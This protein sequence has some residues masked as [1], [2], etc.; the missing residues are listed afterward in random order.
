[1]IYAN[2]EISKFPTTTT[3]T[4][5]KKAIIISNSNNSPSSS[6][7]SNS[8][9]TSFSS[10][11]GK[12]LKEDSFECISRSHDLYRLTLTSTH[13]L[14]QLVQS[15]Y[16]VD[17]LSL[18]DL[19]GCHTFRHKDCS[20]NVGAYICFFFYIKR[21]KGLFSSSIKFPTSSSNFSL[22]NNNNYHNNKTNKVADSSS[23]STSSTSSSLSSSSQSHNSS[24][25]KYFREKTPLVFHIKKL[26]LKFHENLHIATEWKDSTL[27]ILQARFSNWQLNK[28]MR[29]SLTSNGNT[30]NENN[31]KTI[32]KG[33]YEEDADAD[34]DD[35]PNG[36]NNKNSDRRHRRHGFPFTP[37]KLPLYNSDKR[38]SIDNQYS[39][40]GDTQKNSTSYSNGQNDNELDELSIA[41]TS[42][43]AL[44]RKFLIILN[45]KSGQGKTMQLFQVNRN[46]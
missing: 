11:Y 5:T 8:S 22:N 1:M 2:G 38:M 6:S 43:R 33:E 42:Y 17:K 27:R 35:S 19:F 45:P 4:T 40:D 24:K 20:T 30:I 7:I 12:V 25:S 39:K 3:T 21:K 29:T 23:S 46:C 16:T 9:S 26:G 10:E 31:H 36:N 34:D 41:I 28:F 44:Q 18:D 15:P 13:L 37:T 14:L 32:P